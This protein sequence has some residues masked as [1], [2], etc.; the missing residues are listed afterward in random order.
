MHLRN[1]LD[2]S[3]GFSRCILC[4]HSK[5]IIHQCNH[6]VLVHYGDC[7]RLVQ[8]GN[9][10]RHNPL[11]LKNAYIWDSP[12][13]LQFTSNIQWQC[14]NV[15]EVEVEVEDG[16]IASLTFMQNLF[17]NENHLLI[18]LLLFIYFEGLNQ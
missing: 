17:C 10:M 7:C 6:S 2:V 13:T 3:G 9:I 15:R 12:E 16:F 14:R 11:S 8:S 4:S 18:F 5:L 1:V